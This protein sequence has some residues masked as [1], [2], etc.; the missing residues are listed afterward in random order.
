MDQIDVKGPGG[1]AVYRLAAA[2]FE[3]GKTAKIISDAKTI[4]GLKFPE[5]D[6]ISPISSCSSTLCA[7]TRDTTASQI[8][9]P[10]ISSTPLTLSFFLIHL[11]SWYPAM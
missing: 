6:S 3:T 5:K 7:W 8:S 1:D 4:R 9:P 2:E 11:C 10:A